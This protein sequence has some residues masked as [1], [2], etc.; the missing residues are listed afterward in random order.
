M[1]AIINIFIYKQK[2]IYIA[3]SLRTL[4]RGTGWPTAV[5]RLWDGGFW[6]QQQPRGRTILLRVD[7]G[8]NRKRPE[9]ENPFTTVRTLYYFSDRPPTETGRHCASSSQ[10]YKIGTPLVVYRRQRAVVYTVTCY[11]FPMTSSKIIVVCVTIWVKTW[12][13][14]DF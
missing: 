2:Q 4:L 6:W 8:D 7:M 11:R 1:S 13:E 12:K 10:N 9:P 3:I 14:Q 5:D